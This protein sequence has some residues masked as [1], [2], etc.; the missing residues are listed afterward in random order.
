MAQQKSL[1][2]SWAGTSL[3]E[4]AALPLHS[5]NLCSKTHARLQPEKT[6]EQAEPRVK[7]GII[8]KVKLDLTL[9]T[10]YIVDIPRY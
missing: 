9:L 1:G 3:K 2:S 4:G 6:A 8:Q 7:E 10:K 5:L